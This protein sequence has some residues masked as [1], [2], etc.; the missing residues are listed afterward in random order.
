MKH[1]YSKLE[2]SL[3]PIM[4]RKL[5]TLKVPKSFQDLNFKLAT[6]R[7]TTAELKD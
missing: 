3:T 5:T 4:I 1:S 2:N 7:S 6:Q